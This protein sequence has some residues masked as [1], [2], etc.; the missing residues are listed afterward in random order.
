VL[1]LDEDATPMAR[2][3]VAAA[4]A[5]GA[6]SWVVQ[7]GA[8]ICRFGFAPLAA[9]RILVWGRSSRGQLTRWG[10]PAER[11]DVVGSPRHGGGKPRP[12]RRVW[13]P[14]VLLL[15]TTPPRDDRP[16]AVALRLTRRTYADMLRTA[17]AG[18][19]AIPGVELIVKLHPR[20]PDDATARAV[21]AEFPSLPCRVVTSGPVQP[22]LGHV[23]C[24]LSCVSSAGIEATLAG[25]PVIQ[26]LPPGSGNILPPNEW[27][28]FGNARSEAELAGLLA[29]AFNGTVGWVERS[30]T[31]APTPNLN[32][33][34]DL[35][36]SAAARVAQRVLATPQAGQERESAAGTERCV[37]RAEPDAR[38]PT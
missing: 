35:G 1:V 10:V 8:P 26:L 11:I 23:G 16:D 5:V 34:A 30:E 2:A 17:L 12:R 21:L 32:V 4:R 29:E 27:G 38:I 25:V 28:L 24:V 22:W 6:T 13:P 14:R 33:F 31:H 19:S 37:E 18:V 3:A 36:A 9:D 15:T 20:A 7:H